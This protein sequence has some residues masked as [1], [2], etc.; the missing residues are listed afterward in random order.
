MSVQW[1]YSQYPTSVGW[2]HLCY[3]CNFTSKRFGG[4]S[5]DNLS[6]KISLCFQ[7]WLENQLKG[8]MVGPD[9]KYL[10][11]AT[12]PLEIICHWCHCDQNEQSAESLWISAQVQKTDPTKRKISHTLDSDVMIMPRSS[13][14]LNIYCAVQYTLIHVIHVI[15]IPSNCNLSVLP[16]RA[17]VHHSQNW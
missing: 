8:A 11:V 5:R 4:I 15:H 7:H 2:K 17:S 9:I 14:E 13:K 1:W 16:R 12:R 6:H 3:S 10:Q